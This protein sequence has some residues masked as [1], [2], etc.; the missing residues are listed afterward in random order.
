MTRE[1]TINKEEFDYICSSRAKLKAEN[2]AL[3]LDKHTLEL[4][5]EGKD[6]SKA[7]LKAENE[8]LKKELDCWMKGTLKKENEALKKQL[9]KACVL[10]ALNLGNID[11]VEDKGAVTINTKKI[12]KDATSWLEFIRGDEEWL[13]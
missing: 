3:K 1:I 6:L 10:L 4:L 7:E 2:E 13:R 9:E 8:V 11:D 5:C 12:N